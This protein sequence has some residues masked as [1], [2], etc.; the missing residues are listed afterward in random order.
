MNLPKSN[1]ENYIQWPIASPKVVSC[2]EATRTDRC[3]VTHNAYTRLLG[4]LAP[5]PEI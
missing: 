5:Q 2:T 4:R 3:P 1:A